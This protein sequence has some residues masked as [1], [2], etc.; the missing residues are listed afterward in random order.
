MTRMPNTRGWTPSPLVLCGLLL[1][2]A[3]GCAK[4]KLIPRT[5]IPDTEANREVLRVV[6]DYRRAMEGRDAAAV[7]ALVHP[8]YSDRCGTPEGDDDLD[9]AEMKKILA[10]RLK[11][12]TR[13]RFFIEYQAVT[14]RGRDALVDVWIDATFVYEHADLTPKWRRFTDY[15]RFKLLKDGRTWRFVAGL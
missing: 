15:N 4:P 14:A 7:L 9:Y 1:C 2:A 8:T 3:A 6:E 12:A 13:I 5:K 10:S 11:R